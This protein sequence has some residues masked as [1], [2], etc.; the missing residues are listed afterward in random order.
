MLCFLVGS[1]RL[2][3]AIN[4]DQN[5]PR[6]VI[7]L[8]DHF[9]LRNA[10]FLATRQRIRARCFLK[11]FH[12]IGQHV[13]LNQHDQ[14]SDHDATGSAKSNLIGRR[15]NGFTAIRPPRKIAP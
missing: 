3:R 13:N 10:R 8:L 11:T 2:S 14:H 7:G 12:G 6:R 1:R 9:E 5:K 15:Q 4:L